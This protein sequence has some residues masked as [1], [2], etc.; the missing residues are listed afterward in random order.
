MDHQYPLQSVI[1]R[2]TYVGVGLFFSCTLRRRV[3]R[4]CEIFPGYHGS[5]SIGNIIMIFFFGECA[6]ECH[7]RRENSFDLYRISSR[8]QDQEK[9]KIRLAKIR[10]DF[11]PWSKNLGY[12]TAYSIA[13][14]ALVIRPEL[15][16]FPPSYICSRETSVSLGNKTEI[17]LSNFKEGWMNF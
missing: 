1:S 14:M 2:A 7:N 10:H 6:L 11:E 13:F 12:L 16:T 17:Y 15:Y 5:G 4:N 8:K 9:R 3:W